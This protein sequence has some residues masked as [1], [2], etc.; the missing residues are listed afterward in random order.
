MDGKQA[1]GD[2]RARHGKTRSLEN[3][4]LIPILCNPL[5]TMMRRGMVW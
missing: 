3:V 2:F 4:N 5:L 1:E